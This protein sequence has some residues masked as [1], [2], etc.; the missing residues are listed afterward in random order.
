MFG[1]SE[2]TLHLAFM[3]FP[4]I[5]IFSLMKLNTVFF[6][7]SRHNALIL[8]VFFCTLP[9]FLV[10]AGNIM[11]DIPTVAFL[12]LA[13]AGF[14]DGLENGTRG[15][16]WLGSVALTL[17]VFTS[18][19]MLA[20]VVLL[21]LYAFFRRKLTLRS[22]AAIA[23]PMLALM[24][25]LIVVYEMYDIIPVFKSKLTG[26]EGNVADE[27][28]KGLVP[29]TMVNK[30][31]AIFAF[32]GAAMLWI[33]PLHYALR[34][35]MGRFFLLFCPLMI[36]SYLAT[37]NLTDYPFAT[38]LFFSTLVALG[39]LTLITLIWVVLQRIKR[40]G[41]TGREIYLL[42]WVFCVIGYCIALLPHSSARYLLPAFPPALMLLVNGP[43]WSFSTWARRIGLSCVFCGAVLFALASAYSDYTYADT[44]RDF[45]HKTK[46]FRASGGNS[47]NI[48]YIG[49]W[50]M[51]YYMDKAG[52]R[53]LHADSN[54]PVPGDYMVIP[55]MPAVW[56]PSPLVRVRAVLDG[57]QLYRS[58]LPLR[59]FNIWSHAGFYA[60]FWGML[61]FAF[62][63][64][65]DEV[66][67]VYKVVW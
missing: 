31:F 28:R 10:N 11:T 33:I 34:K 5:A 42:I 46:E 47:F 36:I 3:I 41:D 20:F 50:G 22:T 8:A 29:S 19:Q 25:W 40:E 27:I 21:F 59:L 44:Y 51:H 1:E 14:S 35:A 57:E 60:H 49:E 64:E 52:A 37:I 66:I 26:I 63:S 32:F 56:T 62:S 13:M 23:F 17:A 67:N 38:K 4:L 2:I 39:L 43:V 65:P 45:A 24:M 58:W 18:Y 15:M 6:P 48:W 30:I 7:G 9:A 16:T 55:K 12:L 61:P 53:Y 54:E